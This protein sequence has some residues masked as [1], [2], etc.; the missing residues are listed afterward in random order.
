MNITCVYRVE[1]GVNQRI[2]LTIHNVSFGEMTGQ[3]VTEP[4]PHT[5]RPR[6][7]NGV[8]GRV[9][10]LR[11]YEAPW[12]EVR[13]PRACVCDNYTSHLTHPMQVVSASRF[14]ELH[15]TVTSMNVSEDFQD[16]YFHA[17]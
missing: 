7:V 9:A 3:C 10:E 15:F 8:S 6:C 14:L 17:G 4:D 2:K 16:V 12:R 13:V 1:A 11:I 5:G